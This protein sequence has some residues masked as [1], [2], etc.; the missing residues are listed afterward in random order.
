MVQGTRNPW[1]SADATY[2]TLP[3]TNMVPENG[4]RKD[5]APLAAPVVFHGDILSWALIRR[6]AIGDPVILD[7]SGSVD[8]DSKYDS[9]IGGTPQEDENTSFMLYDPYVVF[10]WVSLLYKFVD[11]YFIFVFDPPPFY[12]TVH[13]FLLFSGCLFQRPAMPPLQESRRCTITRAAGHLH[14]KV[15]C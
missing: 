4:T 8:H 2:D 5:S 9:P 14:M 15:D 7:N 12:C 3:K 10:L 11:P 13:L 1:P 6:P